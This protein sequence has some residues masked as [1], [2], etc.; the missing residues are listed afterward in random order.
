MLGTEVHISLI[1]R[2]T[3]VSVLPSCKMEAN[4]QFL[5]PGAP[6]AASPR[7]TP[8]PPSLKPKLL[9]PALPVEIYITRCFS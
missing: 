5:L 2:A 4:G 9:A 3:S 7:T 8:P 1:I 6:P